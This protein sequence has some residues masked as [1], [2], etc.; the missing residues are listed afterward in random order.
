M[1]RVKH[2]TVNTFLVLVD[3]YKLED[4]FF[5][6]VNYAT[7]FIYSARPQIARYVT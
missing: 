3:F 4:N 6:F 7:S 2:I 1:V 5:F